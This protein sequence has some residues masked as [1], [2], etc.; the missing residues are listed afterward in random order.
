VNKLG[1]KTKKCQTHVTP[2]RG[3]KI[4]DF[5]AFLRKAL[6]KVPRVVNQRSTEHLVYTYGSEY[7]KLVER[8]LMQPDLARRI[9]P[10][11][12]VTV[13]EVE[14]AFHHE[15]ALTLADVVGRR[16]ELGATG[17]PSMATLQKCASLMSREFQWSS[18][19]QQQEIK[20]VIQT[21]PLRQRENIAA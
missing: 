5:G 19:H 8:V 15:M 3:G 7:E 9:C 21:Y 18:V 13:A 6:R 20:S 4:E 12:P 1:I 17:L 11:L 2:V 10:P 14:H 16:T